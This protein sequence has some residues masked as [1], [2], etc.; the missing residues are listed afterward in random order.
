MI[1]IKINLLTG[2]QQKLREFQETYNRAIDWKNHTG[3][4]I[5]ADDELKGEATVRGEHNSRLEVVFKSILLFLSFFQ[6]IC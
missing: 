1:E 3:Q 6:L 2:I 5:L 4:G